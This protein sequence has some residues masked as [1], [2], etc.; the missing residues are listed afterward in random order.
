MTGWCKCR[1]LT[2][3]PRTESR[4]MVQLTDGKILQWQLE[5]SE[6]DD[7]LNSNS[8]TFYGRK[9]K[10]AAFIADILGPS[11]MVKSD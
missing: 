8:R 7:Q 11:D 4:I 9:S 2:I 10:G 1:G 5:A 6:L 3:D